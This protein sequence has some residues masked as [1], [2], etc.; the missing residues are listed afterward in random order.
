MIHSGV[1]RVLCACTVEERQPGWMN[2][3]KKGWVKAEYSMLPRST[4]Q[5]S[6]RD[7]NNSNGRTHEIQRLIGRS[8]RGA[9][10]LEQLGPRTLTLDC[11]VIV[12]DAGT[13]TASITGGWVA[14]VLACSKLVESGK[15]TELPFPHQVAALSLGIVDGQVMTDLDYLEDSRAGTDLNLVMTS[16]G[17]IIEIQGTAEGGSFSRNQLEGILDAGW[18][19]MQTLFEMQ[20]QALQKAGVVWNAVPA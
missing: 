19:S 11:D 4:H 12:A 20:R 1:T 5:R 14:L 8:L 17:G 6:R 13:R 2:D 9:T 16:D 3:P 15:L 10:N 7:H 18:K